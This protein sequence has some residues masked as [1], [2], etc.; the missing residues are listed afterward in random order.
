MKSSNKIITI[1]CLLVLTTGCSSSNSQS[2][3]KSKTDWF[4]NPTVWGYDLTEKYSKENIILLEYFKNEEK[5]EL[6]VFQDIE[7]DIANE[8]ITD[9]VI[10]FKNRFDPQRTGYIGQHTRQIECPKEF[11]PQY[12]E[13]G[14]EKERLKYFLS[15]AN[16]NFIT[17]VCATDLIKYSSAHGFLYCEDKKIMIEIHYFVPQGETQDI[18]DF[19][20]KIDCN[21]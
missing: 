7:K 5:V 16:D 10:L 2:G 4:S 9:K 19:I 21:V 1:I 6:K 18:N 14:A 3:E 17:G 12:F 13:V 8:I 11:K 20:Q 15:F